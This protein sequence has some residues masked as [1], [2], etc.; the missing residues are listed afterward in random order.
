[1]P[2]PSTATSASGPGATS[3]DGRSGRRRPGA[4]DPRASV[5]GGAKALED[6]FGCSD[7]ALG[8]DVVAV[9]AARSSWCHAA[10]HH[11]GQVRHVVTGA[12]AAVELLGAV[13]DLAVAVQHQASVANGHA[14]HLPLAP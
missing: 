9:L 7:Q 2:A 10:G 12:G 14:S 4:R 1:M 11:T 3:S 8:H 6:E 13:G 5:A